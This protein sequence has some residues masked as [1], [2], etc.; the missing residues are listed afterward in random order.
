MKKREGDI[1]ACDAFL[2]KVKGKYIKNMNDK[3][4]N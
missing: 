2:D 3:N 1:K 4:V